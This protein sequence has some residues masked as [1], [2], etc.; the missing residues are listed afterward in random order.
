M[1]DALTWPV[2]VFQYLAI[3]GYTKG[4]EWKGFYDEIFYGEYY[5]LP[6]SRKLT[7]L[8]ILCDEV[9]ASEELKAEMN[10]REE[11]ENLQ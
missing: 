5:L 11:S 1:V 10:M 8:Q 9:L 2:F 7:I 4:P 3:F 6:A